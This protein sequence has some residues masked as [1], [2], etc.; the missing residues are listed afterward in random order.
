MGSLTP[1]VTY[2]YESPDGGE[3]VYARELGKAERRLVGYSAK[4]KWLLEE[5]RQERLWSDIRT[6]AQNNPAL[7]EALDRAIIIYELGKRN[8]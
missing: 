3:T 1:G 8:G 6:A 2:I 4:A 7:Q 5:A